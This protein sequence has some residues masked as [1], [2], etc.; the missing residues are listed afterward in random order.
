MKEAECL[1]STDDESFTYN[2]RISRLAPIQEHKMI[3]RAVRDGLTAERI[4]T[5]LNLR[6]KDIQ[7]SLRLSHISRGF[8][9]PFVGV[10]L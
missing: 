10:V 1:I 7:Q 9:Q 5:A 6:V 3:L 8:G 2:A 4:A